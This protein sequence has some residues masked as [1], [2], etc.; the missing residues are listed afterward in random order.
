MKKSGA[1]I[2]VGERPDGTRPLWIPEGW[3]TACTL[4]A[5][6][7]SVCVIAGLD[8][9]NLQAVAMEAR[10]RWPSLDMVLCADFDPVGISKARE[11]ALVA[12]ARILLPPAQ[13]PEGATDW[14]DVIIANR[15][16]VPHA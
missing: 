11:A 16:G 7:P 12:R 15:Q 8:A 3:A 6:R 5:L 9:G 2:P 13:T 14:N 1:F 10:R 4:Q